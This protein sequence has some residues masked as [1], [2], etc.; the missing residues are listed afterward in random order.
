MTEKKIPTVE[1]LNDF[2]RL[3]PELLESL[4][5]AQQHIGDT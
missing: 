4:L 2:I 3:K 5:T 1:Q